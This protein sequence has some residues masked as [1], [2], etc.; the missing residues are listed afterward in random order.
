MSNDKALLKFLNKHI[1]E[2]IDNNEAPLYMRMF[3]MK[4]K[5][6]EWAGTIIQP[7]IQAMAEGGERYD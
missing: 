3:S 6:L 7:S 4:A 5:L 1:Q 2:A